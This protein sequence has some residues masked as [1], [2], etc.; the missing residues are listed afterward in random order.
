MSKRLTRGERTLH[1]FISKILPFLVSFL[2]GTT[3]LLL[4]LLG[5]NQTARTNK[6]QP[7]LKPLISEF[8]ILSVDGVRFATP[9]ATLLDATTT[10][11]W[12]QQVDDHF[13]VNKK[14]ATLS[15]KSGKLVINPGNFGKGI[16]QTQALDLLMHIDLTASA[17]ASLQ[18]V[19]TGK[20]L[21]PDE[22]THIRERYQALVNK[23]L[24]FTAG[25]AHFTLTAQ[26]V[27]AMMALPDG[28]S[29]EGITSV[30]KSWAK[31]FDHPAVEPRLA[32][33]GTSVEAFEAPRDG[34]VITIEPSVQIVQQALEGADVHE[35]SINIT[36]PKTSLSSINTLGITERLG[37]GDS[38]YFHSIPNRITNVSLTTSKINGVLV[39]PGE[40]FSF[41][42]YLG[43]VSAATGFKQAY[44]ISQGQTILG[45]GGGVCQVS[46]TMFR[47]ILN[48]GLPVTERRG[49]SYRV[50]YY[51][52]NSKP[53]FDAT[54][55]SPHPDLRF[56]NDTSTPILIMAVADSKKL[57]MY[58]ELWGKSDGRKAE[59]L[60]YKQWGATPALPTVYQDDPTLPP[61]KLKQIDFAAPGLKVSFDYK[62]TYSDGQSKTVNFLTNYVPWRAVYLRGV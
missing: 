11:A 42:K 36:P 44:I 52:Q 27:A 60:N 38:T 58:V 2:F 13:S 31:D 29:P 20:V 47:A 34:E 30:I 45:D 22:Q 57:A 56:V 51:E 1:F 6:L 37:R 40:E 54:V 25:T 32:I 10:K 17:E 46:S 48:A 4:F 21:D 26:N 61:G 62:V 39:M 8:F 59:I 16:D 41:A 19:S 9:S 7:L 18:S 12:L 5:K 49:H 55:Y 24:T 50:G 28:F 23:K 53:G 14:D 33:V 43:E 15:V 35:L 3:I